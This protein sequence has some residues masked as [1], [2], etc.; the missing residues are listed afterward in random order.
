MVFYGRKDIIKVTKNNRFKRKGKNYGND[1]EMVW[2]Q[3]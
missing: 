3:I 1:I 2:K